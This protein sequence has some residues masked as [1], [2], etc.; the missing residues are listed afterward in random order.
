MATRW[1]LRASAARNCRARR[2][3]SSLRAAG[4]T[5]A[6]FAWGDELA[7]GGIHRANTWQGDFP[8]ENLAEDGHA[9]TSPVRAFPA[10][11][12]GLFDMIGNVWEWTDDWY[13][14][15]YAP[16][17]ACCLPRIRAVAGGRTASTGWRPAA[18]L[19]ARC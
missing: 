16:A 14:P 3:G 18:R 9:G 5:A 6:D 1:L 17:K 15:H 4:S 11:G 8:W 7:P 10:N 12:Y 2:N 13:A 19:P